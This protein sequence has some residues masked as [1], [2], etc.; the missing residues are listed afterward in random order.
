M[1]HSVF[2]QW[3]GIF[4]EIGFKLVLIEMAAAR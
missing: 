3:L 1:N 2:S 4:A